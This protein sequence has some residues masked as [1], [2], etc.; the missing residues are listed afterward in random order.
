MK[1]YL[2]FFLIFILMF[3]CINKNIVLPKNEAK[4]NI[5]V[6][7]YYK[8]F[9]SILILKYGNNLDR[10][11]NFS[12]DFITALKENKIPPLY[13]DINRLLSC[14]KDNI[15]FS[16]IWKKYK[17][18]CYINMNN[19]SYFNTL[20][21]LSKNNRFIKN[22]VDLSKNYGTV[23]TPSI[24]VSFARESN[25]INFQNKNYRIVF[26]IH[27]ITIYNNIEQ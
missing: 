6:L 5:E 18:H 3:S 4:F 9:D 23:Y 27:Y 2:N 16:T 1:K 26:A 19:G 20:I 11:N 21:I 13:T 14:D 22:Y 15:K 25:D 10:F 17:N 12:K 24:I 8:K 7:N